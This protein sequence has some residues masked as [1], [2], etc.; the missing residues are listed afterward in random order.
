[1][2]IPLKAKTARHPRARGDAVGLRLIV[3]YKF[4]KA[5]AECLVAG[6]MLVLGTTHV[7]ADLRAIA[8]SMQHHATEAW[9]L[10]LAGRL[11]QAATRRTVVLVVVAA[12][13]DGVLSYAEGWVLHRRYRWSR[14]LV[15]GTTVSFLPLEVIELVRRLSAG[16]VVLL[17]VNLLIVVYLLRH[18]VA[19]SHEVPR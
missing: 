17:I 19:A 2:S 6:L 1:M 18:R 14:W 11:V 13:L 9:S 16:R 7:T 10:A 12:S 5:S 4:V 15:I 3:G 8:L